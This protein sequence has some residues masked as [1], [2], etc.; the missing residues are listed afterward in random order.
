MALALLVCSETGTAGARD[1]D[2]Q[3]QAPSVPWQRPRLTPRQHW[4]PASLDWCAQEARAARCHSPP[5]GPARGGPSEVLGLVRRLLCPAFHPESHGGCVARCAASTALPPSGDPSAIPGPAVRSA[6]PRPP[7]RVGRRRPRRRLT[8]AF[9]KRRPGPRA[10]RQSHSRL[11]RA[12]PLTDA[13]PV[14][15]PQGLCS[16][17]AGGPSDTPASGPARLLHGTCAAE[18]A[19]CFGQVPGHV[20]RRCRCPV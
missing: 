6:A 4:A 15:I 19:V 7:A 20:A 18:T 9:G 13:M 11:N 2:Q 10:K 8:S 16:W 14:S 3:C 5:R 17:G 1:T 12:P